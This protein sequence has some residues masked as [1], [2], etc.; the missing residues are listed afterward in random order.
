MI[1]IEKIMEKL[2]EIEKKIDK[3]VLQEEDS[4]A[5]AW[6]DYFEDNKELETWM[7]EWSN[8]DNL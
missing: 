1:D 8:E 4:T 7:G 5:K 3:W 2:L 6:D